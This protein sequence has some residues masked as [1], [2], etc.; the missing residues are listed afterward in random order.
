METTAFESYIN[1]F[2][3]IIEY[4]VRKEFVVEIDVSLSMQKNYREK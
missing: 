3:D 2:I 4:H 1:K